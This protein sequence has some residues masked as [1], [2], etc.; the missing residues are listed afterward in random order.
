LV[1]D[2]CQGDSGGPVMMF[3]SGNQWVLVGL[4]S[5]GDGCANPQYSGVYT[6][7]AAYESWISSNTNGN[8]WPIALSHAN[9]METSM[10]YILLF[11]LFLF[12]Y[13]K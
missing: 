12:F 6:R 4:T 1:I 3:T 9:T 7:V 10:Y 13:F 5:F 2:T 8:C 11:V